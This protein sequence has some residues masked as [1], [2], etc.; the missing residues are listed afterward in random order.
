MRIPMSH[1]DCGRVMTVLFCS[2][3]VLDPRVGHTMDV[4]F[5]HS[6]LIL[7]DTSTGSPV[8]VLMLFIQCIIS[9]CLCRVSIGALARL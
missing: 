2:L 3:A 8:H 1:C 5:L 4:Y 6:S 9:V 7:I